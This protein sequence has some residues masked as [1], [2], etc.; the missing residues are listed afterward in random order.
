MRQVS[1]EET[2]NT[3]LYPPMILGSILNPI[4]SSMLAV[5]LIP[6]AQAFD[7]PFYQTT[8]LV[9]SLYLATSIGQPVIGKLI[10]IFG[11]RGLFLFAI[12]LVGVASLI[13]IFTPSFYG[14]VLARFLIGIGTCAGYPSAMYLISYEGK[15]TGKDSPSKILTML[16]ISNQTISVIGPTIGGLLIHSGGWQAIFLVNVPLSILSFVFG[17]LYY[18][19]VESPKKLNALKEQIDFI[20]ITLFTITLTT[21]MIFFMEPDQSIFYL[22]IIGLFS[23]IAFVIM[24]LKSQ[25]PFIDLRVLGH[26]GALNNTYVR[27]LLTAVISYSVLYGY[28]QWLE[29]GRGLTAAQAGL[30][31]I[32]QFLVGIFIAQLTGTR[33]SIKFK[34]Y[35]GTICAL[36]TMIGFQFLQADTPLWILILLAAIFGVPQGLLNLANQNA[37]YHQAAKSMIGMSAG[38]L[39]TAMYIG[40]IVSSTLISTLFKGDH[41]T[42]GIH[43]LGLFCM[44]IGIVIII[45]T[46]V[47]RR[48]LSAR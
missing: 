31:M 13:A 39:R 47:S 2:F 24:E 40:A 7:I 43:E 8:W 11:P 15:R 5:A 20:G 33:L 25:K 19:K 32:P 45:L 6:I 27:S 34:L 46:F 1:S 48:S 36:I 3:K 28:V 26:N 30:M 10:D 29:E 14:L 12:S 37:L 35:L 44:L 18:P 42:N 21:W 22:F 4:N 17:F 23:L 41:I 38:L 16:S 9:S